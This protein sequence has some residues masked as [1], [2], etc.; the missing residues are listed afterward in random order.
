M[1]RNRD[2]GGWR[3]RAGGGGRKRFAHG[4][5]GTKLELPFKVKRELG[6]VSEDAVRRRDG[7]SD[8]RKRRRKVDSGRSARDGDGDGGNSTRA[9]RPT[10]PSSAREAA[11][12]ED[13]AKDDALQRSLAK[14]LKMKS[15]SA[16]F[17]V[18][19]GLNELIEGLGGNDDDM[20]DSE[21]ESI[22]EEE[23]AFD[24]DDRGSESE[25]I[26]EEEDDESD[27]DDDDDDDDDTRSRRARD[28]PSDGP[29]PSPSGRP[30]PPI[31]KLEDAVVRKLRGLL[32]RVTESNVQQIVPDIAAVMRA[33]HDQRRAL[34][35]FICEHLIRASADGPRASAQY[36]AVT[37]VCMLAIAATLESSE[38]V[39]KFVARI[40][41]EMR[42]AES[43]EDGRALHNLVLV[44]VHLFPIGAISSGLVYSFLSHLQQGFSETE[45]ECIYTVMRYV[46]SSLRTA[47]PAGMKDF[48]VGVHARAGEARKAFKEG[49]TDDGGI[50]GGEGRAE[51]QTEGT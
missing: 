47:N 28:D 13:I 24:A 31:A 32:N 9:S 42:A 41:E 7:S 43:R 50:G 20:D 34:S 37:S 25:S 10:A 30:R 8:A 44:F 22:S 23:E 3:R 49:I 4:G 40:A 1:G 14:K 2:A 5:G 17:T 46:G 51:N 21:P 48:V 27:D 39:A 11:L 12:R 36:A 45:V 15:A 35:D 18:D 26:P 33:L 16:K 38:F 19:D 6:I 29:S